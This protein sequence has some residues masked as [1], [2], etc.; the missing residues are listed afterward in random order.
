MT[1]R[2]LPVSGQTD[3]VTFTIEVGGKPLPH[4]IPVYSIEVI[5]EANRVPTARICF[6]D[7]N[8]ASQEWPLS[9]EGYFVPGNEVRI[10]AGYHGDEEQI[11]SGIMTSQAL[12]V[13]ERR[14]ELQVLCKDRTV[15]LT[16]TRKSRHFTDITDSDAVARILE[17]YEI[18]A[19][20]IGSTSATHT[21]LVQYDATDWDFIIMRMEANGLICL[22][23][24]E[25]LHAIAP[26]TDGEPAATL[27]FGANV[28]EF[29]ADIDARRQY[30]AVSAQAWDAAAQDFSS[31]DGVDP[32]WTTAGNMASADM[33]S[34]VGADTQIMRHGAG[35][36][37]DELQSWSDAMLL[38]SRMAFVRGRARV[39]GLAAI[40]PNTIVELAGFGDRFN[41]PVWVGAVRHE[42]G[43]GSWLTDIEFGMP[44]ETHAQRYPASALPAGGLLPAVSGLH[45]GIVTALEGDP[46]GEAR[47]RVKVPSVDLQGEGVWAR[48]ATLDAGSSRGT[49][50]LPEIDDEVV[51]GFFNDDPRHP[52]VLGMVHSSA[53]AP[54]EEAS[55]DND[56]KGFYSRSGMRILFD[57]KDTILTIDTPKGQTV[58]LD[59]KAKKVT[60]SDSHGNKLVMSSSGISIESASDLVLKASGNV[61]IEGQT[62]LELKAGAQWKAEGNA[63]AEINSSAVTVVKGS[64]VQIN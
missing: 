32:S 57:D 4:S 5:R 24:D 19:G 50:F 6:S 27:Q 40:A 42:V 23:D 37:P 7:G 58:L 9:S 39:Q 53:H 33:A 12:R 16:T 1:T 34:A 52:V 43:L 47:I 38:R 46:A 48:V 62:N 35:L 29:D 13:R 54:P 10:L 11:F 60:C 45:T 36:G 59:D 44:E 56:L 30:G 63:G 64:L 14:L 22:A 15:A 26:S 3:L 55:D 61:K 2:L 20:D 28:I 51:V 41:G 17:E 21:D 8:A 18:P 25:G 31:A 49:T